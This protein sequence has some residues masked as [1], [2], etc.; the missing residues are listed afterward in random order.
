MWLYCCGY[1]LCL[2]VMNYVVLRTAFGCE[3]YQQEEGR[4]LDCRS[5]NLSGPSVSWPRNS[6]AWPPGLLDRKSTD[7]PRGVYK[8]WVTSLWL[9]SRF[10]SS[11][12]V[13]KSL[14]KC[15]LTWIHLSLS[16]SWFLRTVGSMFPQI[17]GASSNY[18][19]KFSFSPTLFS[20]LVGFGW[21]DAGPLGFV[22]RLLVLLPLRL[23]SAVSEGDPVVPSRLLMSLCVS[24]LSTM[25]PSSYFY[26]II[27]YY[28]FHCCTFHSYDFQ[29]GLFNNFF[30]CWNIL[31]F[32]WLQRVYKWLKHLHNGCFKILVR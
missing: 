16:C 23:L 4:D 6:I 21:W 24:I 30:L 7:T 19:F 32:I 26:F 28:I 14:I 10:W 5:L 1:Y 13:F 12:L 15:V 25:S 9:F 17:W 29:L 18:C 2:K 22:H 27:Y 8:H 3:I 20:L 31:F 11:S